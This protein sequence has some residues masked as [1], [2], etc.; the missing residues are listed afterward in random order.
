M[1]QDANSTQ[2]C[3]NV[4][5]LLLFLQNVLKCA[6]YALFISILLFFAFY[7]PVPTCFFL[8]LF[9]FAFTNC[10][11]IVI[12]FF[13]LSNKTITTMILLQTTDMK[14]NKTLHFIIGFQRIE[15]NFMQKGG[16]EAT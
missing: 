1:E 2:C 6:M 11:T 5:F 8:Y 9:L 14:M 4:K 7:K 10:C 3:G 12:L 15:S 13:N 16:N